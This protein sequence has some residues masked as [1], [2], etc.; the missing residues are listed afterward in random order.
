MERSLLQALQGKVKQRYGLHV[1]LSELNLPAVDLDA[2]KMMVAI[3]LDNGIP[4]PCENSNNTFTVPEL[5]RRAATGKVC[6]TP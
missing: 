3:K 4:L 1:K 5:S 2:S 6:D